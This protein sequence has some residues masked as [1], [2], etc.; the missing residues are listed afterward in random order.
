MV[1]FKGFFQV[2]IKVLT[3]NFQYSVIQ[4]YAPRTAQIRFGSDTCN[5]FM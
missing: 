3:P 4:P 5:D 1:K 2:L